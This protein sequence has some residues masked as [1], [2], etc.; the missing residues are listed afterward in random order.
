MFSKLGGRGCC[1]EQTPPLPDPLFDPDP[2]P[3]VYYYIYVKSGVNS[4]FAFVNSSIG[5]DGL[6]DRLPWVPFVD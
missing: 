1:V 4:P 2:G 5:Q 6:R 3:D